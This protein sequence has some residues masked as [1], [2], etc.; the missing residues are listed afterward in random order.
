MIGPLLDPPVGAC[1][2]SLCCSGEVA[3]GWVD[4][5]RQR[6]GPGRVAV[7]TSGEDDSNFRGDPLVDQAAALLIWGSSGRRWPVRSFQLG[8]SPDARPK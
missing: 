4:S 5:V 2:Q 3:G 1:G 7:N 6:R 8:D